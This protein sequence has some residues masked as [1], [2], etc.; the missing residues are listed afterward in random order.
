MTKARIILAWA[1]LFGATV[2][3][4][5][6]ITS[7]HPGKS[8]PAPVMMD[9]GMPALD[10]KPRRAH[11]LS[12]EP[13]L[14]IGSTV[15]KA[16]SEYVIAHVAGLKFCRRFVMLRSTRASEYFEI[17]FS[18]DAKNARDGAVPLTGVAFERSSLELLPIERECIQKE[19]QR[20]VIPT[21]SLGVDI[22]TLGRVFYRFCFKNLAYSST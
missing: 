19:F 9:D 4:R 22:K 1:A 5:S 2:A 13:T 3:V 15:D 14:P 16:V 18:F 11:P 7:R 17:S 8:T 6:F 12:A 21:D 20:F 10:A